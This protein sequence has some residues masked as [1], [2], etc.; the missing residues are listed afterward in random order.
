MLLCPPKREAVYASGTKCSPID[1]KNILQYLCNFAGSG[2]KTQL[3]S[4]EINSPLLYKLF[5]PLPPLHTP[6]PPDPF[7]LP[8]PY[9]RRPTFP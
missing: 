8:K 7:P 1:C 6:S 2:V 5:V 3:F 9:S 4:K